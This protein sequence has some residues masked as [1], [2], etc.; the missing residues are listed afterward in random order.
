MVTSVV[1]PVVTFIVST[2]MSLADVS[3][4]RDTDEVATVMVSE[5]AATVVAPKAGDQA[6][7]HEH[8]KDTD[9]VS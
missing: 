5:T 9:S 3:R 6:D 2:V 8:N 4:M 7:D 1:T